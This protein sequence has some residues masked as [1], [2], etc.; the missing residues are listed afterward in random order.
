MFRLKKIKQDNSKSC[1]EIRLIRQP[2]NEQ[3]TTMKFT[4]T[5]FNCTITTN[6]LQ[7]RL[8]KQNNLDYSTD[9]TLTQ[10]SETEATINW[11]LS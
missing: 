5:I 10:N 1:L 7:I 4:I 6:N 3:D 9:K 11:S 8:I 2:K